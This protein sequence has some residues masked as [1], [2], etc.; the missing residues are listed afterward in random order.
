MRSHS[1]VSHLAR[2]GMAL[3]GSGAVPLYDLPGESHPFGLSKGLWLCKWS[4]AAEV[5]AQAC[6]I[7]RLGR[8]SCC[9][10]KRS[11]PQWKANRTW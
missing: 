10:G 9:R 2:L 8:T 11:G 7:Q 4:V 5:R 1:G 6:A 3:E